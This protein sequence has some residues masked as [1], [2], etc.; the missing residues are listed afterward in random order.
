MLSESIL[1]SIKDNPIATWRAPIPKL[2]QTPNKV[3]II[4]ITSTISPIH[5]NIQSPINGYK[6]DF[7]VKGNFSRQ[8]IKLNSKP[9]RENMAQPCKPEKRNYDHIS[10]RLSSNRIYFMKYSNN[11][12]YCY[13]NGTSELVLQFGLTGYP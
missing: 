2:V 10:C 13:Q 8:H 1:E 4:D 9:T 3:H 11:H 12:Q 7:I 5:P 6:H